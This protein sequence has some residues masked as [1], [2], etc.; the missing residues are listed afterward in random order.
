MYATPPR[1]LSAHRAIVRAYP[2]AR[3][4]RK[5]AQVLYARTGYTVM[6][7]TGLAHPGSLSHWFFVAHEFGWPRQQHLVITYAPPSHPHLVKAGAR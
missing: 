4:F 2:S 5:D 6:S 1:S 3:A 7:A